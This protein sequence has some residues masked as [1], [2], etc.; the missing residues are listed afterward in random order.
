MK[1]N[2]TKIDALVFHPLSPDGI[3]G[4]VILLRRRGTTDGKLP[5][6]V[7]PFKHLGPVVQMGIRVNAGLNTNRSLNENFSVCKFMVSKVSS[8][9]GSIKSGFE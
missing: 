5:V 7:S 8:H 6:S 2:F 3:G 9:R 1:R 4:G